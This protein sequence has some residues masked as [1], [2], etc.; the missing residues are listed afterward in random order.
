MEIGFHC[1][2]LKGALRFFEKYEIVEDI[3]VIRFD[4]VNRRP[5]FRFEVDHEGI[6]RQ[7]GVHRLPVEPKPPSPRPLS[8]SCST[9]C[10]AMR[11]VSL[12][13]I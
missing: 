7:V 6:E 3:A 8:G 2:R 9:S 11:T 4:G 10:H 12:K 13:T 1:D 5:L